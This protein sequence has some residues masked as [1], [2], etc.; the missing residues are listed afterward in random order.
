L[1][2]TSSPTFKSHSSNEDIKRAPRISKGITD[3]DDHNTN[4]NEDDELEGLS[5]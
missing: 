3:E 1:G 2:L 4:W 5:E